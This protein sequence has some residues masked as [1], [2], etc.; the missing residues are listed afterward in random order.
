MKVELGEYFLMVVPETDFETAWLRNFKCRKVFHKTGLTP[1][2][3]LGLKITTHPGS[4]SGAYD[5]GEFIDHGMEYERHL[6][7][8]LA[9]IHGDG[10]HYTERCG[11]EKS[12]EDAKQIVADAVVR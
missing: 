2:D 4:R 8:L 11:L 10:G 1:A 7:N 12:V 6:K 5:L 9:I 3:Y